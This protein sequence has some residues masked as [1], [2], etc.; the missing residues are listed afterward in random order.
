MGRLGFSLTGAQTRALKEICTDLGKGSPMNRLLQ[1]DVGSG[2]SAIAL[3]ASQIAIDNQYSVAYIA[4]TEILARQQARSF[5][6]YIQGDVEL[7]VGS[8]KEKEKGRIKDM[9]ASDKP[10]CVI[11]T[12]ALLQKDVTAARLGLVIIDEQHRFGV[13]QR[14][15][16][17]NLEENI[18][19]HLLSMTATP[20]PRTLNL[21]VYGDLDVSVLDELPPG[22]L[23]VT[24]RLLSSI[25]REDALSHIVE[26]LNQGRQAY[27]IAPLVE[28]SQKLEVASAVK[29]AQA[30]RARFPSAAVE[31]LHGQMS[32]DDK[33][34]IMNSFAAGAIQIL[35]STAVVEV[36]VNVPNA[37]LM[38]IEGAER[39]GIAQLHQFRGRV[40]RGKHKSYCYL[41]PTQ[42]DVGARERLGVLATT[43]DGFVIA[44]EDLRLRGPGEVYGAKQSGFGTLQVA[45]LLDYDMIRLA[46]DEASSLL[47][48]D[49]HLQ[50]PAHD[51]LRRKVEQKNA[52]THFE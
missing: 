10:C 21:T 45:S 8:M 11:G 26:E 29:T 52:I 30:I 40:G 17:Q 31:L 12:H 32:S 7:L 1:G 39:F 2:K 27:V 6:S 23:P 4:P 46:R 42:D 13:V 43:Q 47:V 15:A 16:L 34:S 49:P 22:R 33:E 3:I 36:G 19:P 9:L 48:K 14:K 24:T 44:E 25:Q 28:D 5:A 37:T 50:D 35:V 38:L 51:I 41:L 20:I 18:T